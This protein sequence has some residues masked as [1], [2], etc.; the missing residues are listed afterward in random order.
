MESIKALFNN[1]CEIQNIEAVN[2]ILLKYNLPLDTNT[3]LSAFKRLHTVTIGCQSYNDFI[4]LMSRL[5]NSNT[6][7]FCAIIHA[8]N[9]AKFWVPDL[10]GLIKI[11][12]NTCCEIGTNGVYLPIKTYVQLLNYSSFNLDELDLTEAEKLKITSLTDAERQ[13]WL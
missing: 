1:S 10:Y 13:V 12:N 7:M 6:A 3:L 2:N 8:L 5:L 4:F 11:K 9:D